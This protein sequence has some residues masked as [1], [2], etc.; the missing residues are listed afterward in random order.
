M[1][2]SYLTSGVIQMVEGFEDSHKAG[3]RMFLFHHVQMPFLDGV[4][5][6][7]KKE[8]KKEEKRREEKRRERKEKRKK[9]EKKRKEK[10]RK[11]KNEK[12]KEKQELSS[13]Q[14]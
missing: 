13:V 9:K 11:E 8:R 7:Q 10:G 3:Y 5:N 1:S 14:K 6:P 4:I 12:K 2:T